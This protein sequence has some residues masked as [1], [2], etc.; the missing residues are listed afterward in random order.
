MVG[1]VGSNPIAPTKSMPRITLPDGSL[2]EFDRPVTVAEIAASIGPGLARQALAGRVDGKLVDLSCLVSED[3]TVAIVTDRDPA[4][5]DVV[6]H[7]SAHL[8]AHAVKRCSPTPR[9][10]SGR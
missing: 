10:R 5:L 7:S 4:G 9:S 6:R 3:A 1:V 2:R 8:L